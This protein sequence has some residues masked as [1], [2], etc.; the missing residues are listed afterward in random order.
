MKGN[1]SPSLI[2]ILYY[3]VLLISYYLRVKHQ[4]FRDRPELC[5]CGHYRKNWMFSNTHNG[6]S[7]SAIYNSLIVSARYSNGLSPFEYLAWIFT[8]A[9]DLGRDGFKARIGEFLPSSKDMLQKV[10]TPKPQDTD[11]DINVWDEV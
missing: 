7:S 4:T 5:V 3:S 1:P 9:P 2:F 10:F 11:P 6:A 8:N